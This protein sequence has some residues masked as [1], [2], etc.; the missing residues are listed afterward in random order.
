MLNVIQDESGQESDSGQKKEL[1][2]LNLTDKEQFRESRFRVSMRIISGQE[3]I[4]GKILK[5]CLAQGL[6]L[7]SEEE[8]SLRIKGAD[9]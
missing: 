1:E 8:I 9:F 3:L 4:G 7:H 2:E 5:E 6:T